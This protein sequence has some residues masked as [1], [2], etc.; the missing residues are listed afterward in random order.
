MTN[1]SLIK[2]LSIELETK[3][4]EDNGPM[5]FGNALTKALGYRSGD[6]FR[7][8]ANRGTVPIHI[9][10]IETRR[11]WF[12]MTKDVAAWLAEQ[13]YPAKDTV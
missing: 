3:L 13:R 6:A 12:A 2:A 10:K 4:Y 9:F 7:K 11:G 8:A 1:E 5:M